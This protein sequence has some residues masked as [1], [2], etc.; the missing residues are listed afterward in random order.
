VPDRLK[1]LAEALGADELARAFREAA[2]R[3]CGLADDAFQRLE[4]ALRSLDPLHDAR[5]QAGCGDGTQLV[6]PGL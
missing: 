1:I 6:E 3:S 4:R 2:E 5:E